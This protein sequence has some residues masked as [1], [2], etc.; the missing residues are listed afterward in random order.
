M[1]GINSFIASYFRNY[2]AIW[3]ERLDAL[4]NYLTRMKRDEKKTNKNI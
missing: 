3:N 4:E 2:Q 1:T